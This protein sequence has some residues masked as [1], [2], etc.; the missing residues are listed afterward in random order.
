MKLMSVAP[1]AAV[2]LAGLPGSP[3]RK[4]VNLKSTWV[5]SLAAI[6]AFCQYLI[7]GRESRYFK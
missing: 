2:M 7:L 4:S 1:P 5:D 3:G 6:L